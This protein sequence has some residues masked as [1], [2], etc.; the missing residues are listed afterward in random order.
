M[1]SIYND[2]DL[3]AIYRQ[4]QKILGVFWAVTAVYAAICVA[5]LCFFISLP[6]KDPMQTPIKTV[7][8]A[9]TPLYVLF[10]FPYMGIKYGR[11]RRYYRTLVQVSINRKS[12]ETHY[13]YKFMK[14]YTNNGMDVHY[15]VFGVWN[16]KHR[17]W[18]ER[19]V[20]LDAEKALPDFQEGDEIR[21]ITQSSYL[22]QYEILKRG[23]VTFEEVDE[24][25]EV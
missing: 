25:D 16:A 8:F 5:C 20:Y 13:F 19:N 10:L 1:T 22:L 17:E 23:V 4:K 9:L 12:L 18:R 15:C 21:Y 2:D 24:D 11:V 6:Y 14:G 3:Y 7:V